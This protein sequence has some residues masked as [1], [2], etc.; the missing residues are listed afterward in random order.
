MFQ[1][2]AI[3]LLMFWLI[4][5]ALVGANAHT[6]VV[7]GFSAILMPYVIKNSV[8]VV[9]FFV[10]FL[11][12]GSIVGTENNLFGIIGVNEVT[13][14]GMIIFIYEGKY[15]KKCSSKIIETVKKLLLVLLVYGIIYTAKSVL[16]T[17]PLII[18]LSTQHHTDF[19]IFKT[20]FKLLLNYIPLIY[21]INRIEHIDILKAVNM[22]ILL[23]V[24][25][26]G[27]TLPFSGF[28]DNFGFY[29]SSL[30]TDMSLS[31]VSIDRI[32]GFYGA[33]GDVNSA[34]VFFAIAF[35]YF[36]SWAE[37]TKTINKILLTGLILSFLGIFFSASRTAMLSLGSVV[38]LFFCFNW[39]MLLKP[40]KGKIV[41]LLFTV[42]MFSAPII[43]NALDR[44]WLDS[45]YSAIDPNSTGRIGKW[46][47]YFEYFKRCPESF[48]FGYVT[49]IYKEIAYNFLSLVPHNVFINIAYN[50]GL[51]L[52]FPFI[53]LLV[54]ICIWGWHEQ[55]NVRIL[56][57]VVP[58]F[59]AL[60]SVNSPGSGIFLWLMIPVYAATINSQYR[61]S[62]QAAKYRPKTVLSK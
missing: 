14:I 38:I 30:E 24:I 39:N 40:K 23:S 51:F 19:Y 25:T 27:I 28:L 4:A 20:T 44:F 36:L 6:Y 13:Q 41:F 35:G 33:G 1:R 45:A 2:F 8:I 9:S 62:S 57:A 12:F 29:M 32:K 61:V 11:A 17:Q 55:K 58:Y 34:G 49:P 53:Y 46:L 26:I 59:F 18:G 43:L 56:Y 60:M 42:F 50:A 37:K 54:K 3:S 31:G 48:I 5:F 47:I 22:A 10:Y 15:K 52:L 16:V 21:I 7:V